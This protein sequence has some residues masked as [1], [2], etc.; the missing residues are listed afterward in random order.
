M[1]IINEV[2]AWWSLGLWCQFSSGS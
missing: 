2:V 1:K